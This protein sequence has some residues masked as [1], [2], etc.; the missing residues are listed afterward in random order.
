MSVRATMKDGIGT[1]VMNLPPLNIVTREA[2]RHV[3]TR[4]EEL[5]AEPTLRVVLFRSEGKHFSAGADVGE[6][7]PG[8]FEEMIPEFM[9]TIAALRDFPLPVVAAVQGR[10]LGGGFELA[11]A[12]DL[13]VAGETASFGQ[14]EILLG[15]TAPAASVV[16]PMIAPAAVAADI[17]FT[18]DAITA[19]DAHR[20][21]LVARVVPDDRIEEA[22]LELCG[23]IA[24]HSGAALRVAKRMLRAGERDARTAALAD[25]ERLYVEALMQTGDATEGL[26][27]FLEK[28]KPVWSHR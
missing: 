27:A 15:V 20:V 19:T 2:L 28:R 7:M 10:C 16:L 9:Q 25:A 1:L 14:P 24:R 26:T 12:A 4:L 3:R 22:A 18:G 23:R 11:Q 21:G 17:L 8:L 6:H 5:A 13:I